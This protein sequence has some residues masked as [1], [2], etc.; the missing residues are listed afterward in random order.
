[1]TEVAF[2]HLQNWSLEKALPRLLEKTLEAGKRA[3]VM[4]GSSDRVSALDSHLWTYNPASWL[5]HGS[6]KA[7]EAAGQPVW[8]TD[9]DENANQASFLFLTD[10]AS[11][12]KIEEFERCF[13]MFDGNDP[14][15][16]NEARRQ[17]KALKD[18]GHS[19]TYW[20]QTDR[21]GWEEK[22]L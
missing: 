6:G 21:G 5:P 9:S 18:S 4:A 7:D 2:Y 10:G 22:S 3:L 13:I 8:L 15:R 17:W 16:V 20:R 14:E 11:S 12:R 19:L 1:M